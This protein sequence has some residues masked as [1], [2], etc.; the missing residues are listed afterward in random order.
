MNGHRE[1]EDSS[2]LVLDLILVSF[3]H[4][5]LSDDSISCWNYWKMKPMPSI[6]VRKS[7][8]ALHVLIFINTIR[9]WNVNLIQGN[10]SELISK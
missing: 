3:S 2:T 10:K 8:N 5:A 1:V 6:D 4:A 7:L 9:H